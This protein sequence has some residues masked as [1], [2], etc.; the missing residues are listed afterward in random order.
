MVLVI[1]GVRYIE[2]SPKNETEIETFINKHSNEIFGKDSFYFDIKKKI[3]TLSG[4][5]T[6][7]DGFAITINPNYWYIVEAE[8]S[9]HSVYQHMIPQ[10]SKF[11]SAWNN[12]N[13]QKE[14][15]E[16]LYQYI[17][18]DKV[19]EAKFRNA[20]SNADIH[21]FLT[22]L[23]A[24]EPILV[25]IID[26]KKASNV[27]EGS[28]TLIIETV[29][30][31]LKTYYRENSKHTVLAHEIDSPLYQIK[32]AVVETQVDEQSADAVVGKLRGKMVR[33]TKEQVMTAIQKPEIESYRFRTRYLTING[34][35]Y[36]IK[37]LVSIITGIPV[38]EFNTIQAVPLLEKL[39]FEI[40]FLKS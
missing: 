13:N 20:V 34:K 5:G 32:E 21:K 18:F 15:V 17:T 29:V 11:I 40:H 1:D 22:D 19:L 2:Y 39:G 33:I 14:L 8:L 37:G 27:E 3:Q 35:K 23:I 31:E 4:V 38:T 26:D 6:I 16:T 36:P 24:T 12:E 25:V 28:K 10:I 9:S 7:P 30:V